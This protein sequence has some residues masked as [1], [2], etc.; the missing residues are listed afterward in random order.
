MGIVISLLLSSLLSAGQTPPVQVIIDH[1][2]S[3]NV[4]DYD[5]LQINPSNMS[6]HW[7]PD[8]RVSF[9][10]LSTNVLLF[11]HGI[12][13]N[14]IHGGG[15]NRLTD[16][17]H[18]VDDILIERN[19]LNFNNT[20]L[21]IN[22]N[23]IRQ[24]S[25]A[26]SVRNNIYMETEINGVL[27]EI[28]FEGADFSNI[29]DIIM[30]T[31]EDNPGAL[32]NKDASYIRLNVINEFNLG[33]S[34]KLV[35]EK[36]I[37]VFGGAGV[38][39]LLGFADLGLEFNGQEVAGYYA[40]SSLLPAG[41]EDENFV[42]HV[43]NDKKFGHGFGGSLG[44]SMR[45]DKIRAGV[46]VIDL[47]FMKWPTRSIYI[48]QQD[49]LIETLT[50]QDVD[51]AINNVLGNSQRKENG[52]ELL[53]AKAIIGGSYDIHQY[54]RF[55]MDVVTPLYSAPRGMRNP[56]IGAGTWLSLKDYITLRTGATLV[57]KKLVTVPMF[58]SFFGGKNKS[59]EMSVGTTDLL[60][61]F[62]ENR[63][64]M[65]F[66]TALMKFHF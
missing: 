31:M 45:M 47:G 24:G 59:F 37:Q 4:H 33:Y 19:A 7:R 28:D 62:I 12:K 65:S 35:N 40:L 27:E 15:V 44:A 30:Q 32:L 42:K 34:R 8:K 6:A 10:L 5:A 1:T 26:F 63:E 38:K 9:G 21:G 56:T 3:A 25:F 18:W 2:N 29:A 46:S 22:V 55:Y 23:T 14:L 57:T 16:V 17:G 66:Q 39:Y 20:L 64:Y 11:S 41:W 51:K 50:Q 13:R 54:V 48:T 61:F 53:P 58:V 43:Q 49:V 36:K 52:V 60:A